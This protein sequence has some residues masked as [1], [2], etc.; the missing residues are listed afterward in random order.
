[1]QLRDLC[2]LRA[3]GRDLYRFINALRQSQVICMGQHCQKGS[4]C[5]TIRQSDLAAVQTLADRCG[6][7]LTVRRHRSVQRWLRR[8]RLRF[9]LAIGAVIAAALIL[10]QSNV[11][12]SVEVQGNATI[13]DAAILNV[14]AG[15][16]IRRGRW[17]PGIDMG[18][19]EYVVRRDLPGIAWCGIR[20]TGSRLVVEV[21]EETPAI[22]L[23]KTRSPCNI[24]AAE[25]AQITGIQ[26]LH[27]ELVRMLGDGVAKGDL[28][29]SGVFED[30]TGIVT[31]HHAIA[32]ITGIYT[33]ETTL[34]CDFDTEQSVPTGRERRERTLLLFGMELP[35]HLP[36]EAYAS[37]SR[38]CSEEPLRF[39]GLTLPVGLRTETIRELDT[40]VLHRTPEEAQLVLQS[41]AVRYEQNFLTDVTVLDRQ[42]TFFQSDTGMTCHL[43]FTVEGEIGTEA[44]F[45]VK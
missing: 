32:E 9:G 24:V 10:W 41:E 25:N 13:S 36:G 7:T 38:T 18:H 42:M 23:R 27:G 28:I 35:L 12:V 39:L 21:A 45:T 14:L 33:K 31:Y 37:A 29:V 15:E 3:S 19:C 8:Y 6:M 11:I 1:M 34:T 44:E 30:A 2:E 22:P 40:T 16:G 43:A 5:C 4:L 20:H 26:V 17:I